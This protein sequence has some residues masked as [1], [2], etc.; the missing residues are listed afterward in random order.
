MLDKEKDAVTQHDKI[1]I[2]SN[3]ML[4]AKKTLNQN[5]KKLHRMTQLMDEKGIK[6]I[7]KQLVK[8]GNGIEEFI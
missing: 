1:F 6:N 4:F 7:L 5:L 2:S 3:G 8:L